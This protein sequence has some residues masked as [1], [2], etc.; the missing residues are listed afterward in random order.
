MGDT[1]VPPGDSETSPAADPNGALGPR[2]TPKGYLNHGPDVEAP[3]WDSQFVG[4]PVRVVLGHMYY[5]KVVLGP[6]TIC[7]GDSVYLTPFPDDV[8]EAMDIGTVLG[9]RDEGKLKREGLRNWAE[10]RW[11]LR[12]SQVQNELGMDCLDKFGINEIVFTKAKDWV[13]LDAIEG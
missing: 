12:P 4:E 9:F 1:A 7:V 13:T 6:Y 2:I 3:A 11:M 10:V 8:G 5:G